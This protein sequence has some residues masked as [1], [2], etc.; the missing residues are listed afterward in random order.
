MDCE[1]FLLESGLCLNELI[2]VTLPAWELHSMLIFVSS[3]AVADI[4]TAI[5]WIC[6]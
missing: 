3:S 6:K 2:N 1:L 5:I 4:K